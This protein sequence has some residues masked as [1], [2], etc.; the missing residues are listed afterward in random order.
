MK[1]Q[2]LIPQLKNVTPEL[3]QYYDNMN[4]RLKEG[5]PSDW[6]GTFRATSK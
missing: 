6:D 3:T 2:F 5:V 1:A 4:E